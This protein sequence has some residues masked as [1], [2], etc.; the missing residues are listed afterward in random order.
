V[1]ACPRAA[2]DDHKLTFSSRFTGAEVKDKDGNYVCYSP[3]ELKMWLDHKLGKGKHMAGPA[4]AAD[5]RGI[6][7]FSGDFG[8]YFELWDATETP[9]FKGGVKGAIDHWDDCKDCCLWEM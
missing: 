7:Y 1:P 8:G 5:K 6:I 2:E 9:S 4:K 3:K